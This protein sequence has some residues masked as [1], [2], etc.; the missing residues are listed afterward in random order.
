M[1][2]DCS[3]YTVPTSPK[4]INIGPK[5]LLGRRRTQYNPMRMGPEDEVGLLHRQP[6]GVRQEIRV[7]GEPDGQR[8]RDHGASGHGHL[9]RG[10][11]SCTHDLLMGG[12]SPCRIAVTRAP[13]NED[14]RERAMTDGGR[15]GG[16]RHPD[17]GGARAVTVLTVDDQEIFLGAAR[18]LI[19]ATPGFEEVGQAD[20][21][22]QALELAAALQPDLVLLDV[23]MPGMDGIETAHRLLALDEHP[24]VVLISLEDATELA[25][26][27][28]AVGVAAHMRKQDLSTRALR[29]LWAQHGG[30][31]TSP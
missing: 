6:A 29:R 21:G 5:R 14:D 12:L 8:R 1:L 27:T 25:T 3:T 18:E 10:R 15:S 17:A 11:C 26:S 24:V 22:Q 2:D 30:S 16:S 4:A 31:R 13:C 7:Q 20:S 19:A 9:P 23:R 28:A